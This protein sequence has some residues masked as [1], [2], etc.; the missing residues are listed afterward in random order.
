MRIRE[1][2]AP[3]LLVLV[4]AVAVVLTGCTPQRDLPEQPSLADLQAIDLCALAPPD[5]VADEISDALGRGWMRMTLGACWFEAPGTS[6]WMELAPDHDQLPDSV[7][8]EDPE[9]PSTEVEGGL[10]LDTSGPHSP[11]TQRTLVSDRGIVIEVNA[12]TAPGDGLCSVLDALG[13]VV[14]GNLAAEVPTIAWPEGTT[15]HVDLCAAV[16]DSD[17]LEKLDVDSDVE[18]RAAN[19]FD[20]QVGGLNSLEISFDSRVLS[21]GD[22]SGTRTEV[23]GQPALSSSGGCELAIDLGENPELARRIEDGRDALDITVDPQYASCADLP[24][25]MD[26]LVRSLAH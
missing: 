21:P 10:V 24:D 22:A 7:T 23:A 20:C 25:A 18:A 11:C 13:G 2:H 9:V 14:L 5:Q 3:L 6:L 17:L 19:H 15:G 12:G 16:A 1:R 8:E 26:S 4:T